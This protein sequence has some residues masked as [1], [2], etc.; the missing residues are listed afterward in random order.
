MTGP[1]AYV[2]RMVERYLPEF[3]AAHG[4]DAAPPRLATTRHIYVAET[5]Q[6]AEDAARRGYDSWFKAHVEL[7][8]AFGSESLFFPGSLDE[9]LRVGTA[10][11]GTPD[12]VR[13]QIA[14]ALEETGTNCL[15]GRFGFGDIPVE[16]VMR[17]V[18]LFAAEIMPA[19]AGAAAP[20]AA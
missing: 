14:R 16:R 1:N 11:V 20:A 6:A 15:I 3:H 19:F 18:E 2:R 9:A 7:W 12:M 5:K 13:D 17:S 10:M 4:K 8:R